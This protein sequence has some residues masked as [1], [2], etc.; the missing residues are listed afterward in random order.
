MIPR[1]RRSTVEDIKGTLEEY[2]EE[3]VVESWDG[4]EVL[5]QNDSAIRMV[6]W[7]SW[8]SWPKKRIVIDWRRLETGDGA[9]ETTFVLACK[10]AEAAETS[11]R[12]ETDGY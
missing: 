12:A 10:K 7:T 11:V 1:H 3:N 4:F 9:K 5:L 2:E 6:R 8:E